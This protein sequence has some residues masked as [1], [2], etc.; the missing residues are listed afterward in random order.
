[1]P[2]CKIS[3][4]SFKPTRRPSQRP[5]LL[6]LIVLAEREGVGRVRLL[7]G[8]S[9]GRGAHKRGVPQKHK[10]EV[11]PP[12]PGDVP[13]TCADISKAR[14]LL[15]YDPKTPFPE[16]IRKLVAWHPRRRRNLLQWSPLRG[17]STS[18]PRRRRDPPP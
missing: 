13:R 6:P 12:Q 10:I 9:I 18:W 3:A 4:N 15:G 8:A 17:I 16:G 5:S 7:A 11:L 14:K 2:L 1:M